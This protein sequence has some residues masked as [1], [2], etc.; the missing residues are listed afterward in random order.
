MSKSKTETTGMIIIIIGLLFSCADMIVPTEEGS[1]Y[2]I[3]GAI[4]ISIGLVATL[5][6]RTNNK[7]DNY[8]ES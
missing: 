5:I 3:S 6:G 1:K 8:S 7:Y 4:L 2:L